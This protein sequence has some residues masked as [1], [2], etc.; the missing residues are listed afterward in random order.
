MYNKLIYSSKARQEKR[1]KFCCSAANDKLSN[2]EAKSRCGLLNLLQS[3]SNLIL[4]ALCIS[5]LL[6]LPLFRF[7]GWK[8]G[9]GSC[10][11]E[12]LAP[13]RQPLGVL[14]Y[15]QGFITLGLD[16]LGL[17]LILLLFTISGLGPPGW[18]LYR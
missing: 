4:F 9:V 14:K 11:K 8:E 1:E 17:W 5:E 7:L 18:M 3:L 15:K 16:S 10:W 13:W 6:R 2:Q 12:Q